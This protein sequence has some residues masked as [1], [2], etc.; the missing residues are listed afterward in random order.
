MKQ[1]VSVFML[2][3][4]SVWKKLILLFAAMIAAEGVMFALAAGDTLWMEDA[5]DV[6]HLEWIAALAFLCLTLFL[7]RSSG[8]SSRQDYTLLRLT[9]TDKQVFHLRALSFAL[10]YLL[11]WA[12]QLM[13]TLVL[14][15]IFAS[16]HSGEPGF[17]DQTAFLAFYRHPFLHS[18]L[19]MEE[20]TRWLRNLMLLAGLSVAAAGF[21]GKQ[22]RKI[23]WSTLV[24][25]ALILLTFSFPMGDMVSDW[26]ISFFALTI[27]CCIS[28]D[29]NWKKDTDREVPLDEMLQNMDGSVQEVESCEET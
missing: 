23:S 22:E 4:Q 28:L 2:T 24:L 21:A 8:G 15:K 9:V 29:S 17:G 26:M 14:C 5:I 18:L 10:C 12:V 27:L 1:S 13:L 20:L 25:T 19:P 6:S 16:M 11:F 7:L 3:L